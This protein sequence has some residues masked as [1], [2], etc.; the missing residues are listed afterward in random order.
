MA[1]TKTKR[2]PAPSGKDEV[3]RFRCTGDQKAL[4]TEAAQ[5]VGLG[6]SAWILSL[7]IREAKRTLG[8]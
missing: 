6:V 7:G 3:I 8:R 5:S 1:K 2:K 4:L